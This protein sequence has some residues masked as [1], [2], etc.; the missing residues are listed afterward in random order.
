[1]TGIAVDLLLFDGMDLMDFSGPWE[2]FLTANRLRERQ[3]RRPLFDAVAF[4]VDGPVTTY[5][6]LVVQPTGAPRDH[7]VLMVP[8]VIDVAGAIGDTRLLTA[9]RTAATGREVVASVC[10]GAYLLHAC[11]L[12]PD[13]WTTHW[14]DVD[15]LDGPGGVR[16]RV[17]E[18]GA[19][20]TGGGI[21]C[22]LDVG[23]H[24]VARFDGLDR[25]LEVAR[26]MDYAWP[27][28]QDP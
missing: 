22:G 4:S 19:V 23:L 7:G 1:M 26:Q 9:L 18:P 5:G 11:D 16:A 8:G 17:V 13:R 25:A 20:V 15:G 3:G 2:V 12:L 24:L 10:T 21:A 28:H 14:E 6:G 27:G